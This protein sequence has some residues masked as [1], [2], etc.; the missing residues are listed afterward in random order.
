MHKYAPDQDKTQ[1]MCI[2]AK[3]QTYGSWAMSLIMLKQKRRVKELLK[4]DLIG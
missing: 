1:Q 3:R 2:R 4:I